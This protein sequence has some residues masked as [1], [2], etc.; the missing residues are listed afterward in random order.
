MMA[1]SAVVSVAI[2]IVSWKLIEERALARKGE[3]A[4]ATWRAWNAGWAKIGWPRRETT[5]DGDAGSV[6]PRRYPAPP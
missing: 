4:G 1:S 3:F 6:A 2:A 5:R